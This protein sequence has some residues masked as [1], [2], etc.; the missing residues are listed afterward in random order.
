MLRAPRKYREQDPD[1]LILIK[2][3]M[4]EKTGPVSYGYKSNTWSRRTRWKTQKRIKNQI[5]ATHNSTPRD[6]GQC[7][8]VYI[9]FLSM[10]IPLNICTLTIKVETDWY[11]NSQFHN[12]ALKSQVNLI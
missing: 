8:G 2:E 11:G 9:P 10:K 4:K 5:E 7:S 6:H 3:K 1:L 12:E